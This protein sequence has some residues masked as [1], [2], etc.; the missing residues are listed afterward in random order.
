MSYFSKYKTTRDL[1]ELALTHNIDLRSWNE[2]IISS[3][4]LSSSEEMYNEFLKQAWN[5][6]TG[7]AKAGLRG[8]VQN[9]ALT[10][11]QAYNQVMKDAKSLEASMKA[12]GLEDSQIQRLVGSITNF[13]ANKHMPGDKPG[14][15][16]SK[17]SEMDMEKLGKASAIPFN[18]KPGEMDMEAL[19]KSSARTGSP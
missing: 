5:A 7:G 11:Q 3:E 8:L 18:K 14:G 10:P 13:V 12:Y 9:Y 6:F 16:P 19:G 4:P 2:A 15:M 17:P 1:C